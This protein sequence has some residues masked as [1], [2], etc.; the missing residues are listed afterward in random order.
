MHQYILTY[1][2]EKEE[3]EGGWGREGVASFLKPKRVRDKKLLVD[4]SNPSLLAALALSR[5]FS[6]FSIQLSFLFLGRDTAVPKSCPFPPLVET[7]SDVVVSQM[8]LVGAIF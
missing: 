5:A 7:V 1:K 2:L 6:L 4:L 3:R 8:S